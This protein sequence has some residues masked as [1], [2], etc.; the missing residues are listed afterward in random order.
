MQANAPQRI[1]FWGITPPP[2]KYTVLRSNVKRRMVYEYTNLLLTNPAREMFT[3]NEQPLPDAK[4]IL[5]IK[6]IERS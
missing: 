1:S 6:I 2:K 3:P 5:K 4:C